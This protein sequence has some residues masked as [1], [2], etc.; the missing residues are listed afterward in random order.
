M[1]TVVFVVA[2]LGAQ[3]GAPDDV[4]ASSSAGIWGWV[5]LTVL[6]IIGALFVWM[7]CAAEEIVIDP[8]ARRVTQWHRF[9]KYEVTR[10][11]WAFTD[12]TG[13]VVERK[14]SK[15]NVAKSTSM[16]PGTKAVYKSSY[17]LSLRRADTVVNTPDRR[18]S[19]PHYP[20]ELP[21][22]ERND[23]LSLEAIARQL[24]RL[25]KWPAK[26]RGYVL[27]ARG[28]YADARG[29]YTVKS[30]PHD[31]ESAIDVD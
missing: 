16:S 4:D 20:L 12:F 22:E 21:M 9:L 27:E 29:S 13:V 28:G 5:G 17:T 2:L 10:N 25:G 3:L 11:E 15:E 8:A 26:R 24:A 7:L 14:V 31:M 6:L 1:L 18:I 19:V 30:M 23:P